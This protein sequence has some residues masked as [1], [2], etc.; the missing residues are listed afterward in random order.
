MFECQQEKN[1]LRHSVLVNVVLSLLDRQK[2]TALLL[3]LN[4]FT[5]LLNS[6]GTFCKR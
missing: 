5:K 3:I 4:L 2:R 1:K 6:Y